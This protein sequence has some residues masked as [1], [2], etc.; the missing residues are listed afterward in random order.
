MQFLMGLGEG[1]EGVINSILSM[2]PLP[3]VNKAYYLVQYIE[4]Q[5]EITSSLF[6]QHLTDN[7]A[8]VASGQS[9]HYEKK[10][11]Q[12]REERHDLLLLQT[13]RPFR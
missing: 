5:K 8:L 6:N 13:E 11:L 10:G 12:E 9:S 1:F 2:D 7:S 4:Y 3:S